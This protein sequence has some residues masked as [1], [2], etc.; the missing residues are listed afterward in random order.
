M[1]SVVGESVP[2]L[3]ETTR[4]YRIGSLTIIVGL[5]PTEYGDRW[6]LSISHPLRYPKWDE[7]K[8]ARMRFI[9]QQVVMAMFLP[10]EDRYINIHPNCFHLWETREP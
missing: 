8:A 7:I 3:P 9:P 4:W 1:S 5:E 10:G 2:G 6:H